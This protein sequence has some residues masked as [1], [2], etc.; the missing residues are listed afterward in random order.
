MVPIVIILLLSTALMMPVRTDG[1]TSQSSSPPSQPAPPCALQHGEPTAVVLGGDDA[2][3]GAAWAMASLGIKTLLVLTHRRDLGGDP[4]SF[5]HD[6]GHMVRTGGGLNDML[7]CSTTSTCSS[8]S[9]QE[10]HGGNTN[11]AGGPGAAFLFFDTLLRTSPLNASLEIIE[12]YIALPHSGTVDAAGR[13]SS[14]TLLHH[15]GSTCSVRTKY[16][17]DGSPEGYGA[18][19]FSLPVVFGREALHNES[20]DDPTTRAEPYAGRRSFS[21]NGHGAPI[22]A[23]SDRSV[24]TVDISSGEMTAAFPVRFPEVFSLPF[25]DSHCVCSEPVLVR[26]INS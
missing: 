26:S 14:V 5:Y 4:S 10:Q 2:G 18:A 17:V 23:W 19:A 16:A 20:T 9:S 15:D 24:E 13:V 22:E 25:Q 1:R 3:T 8:A 21:V 6:G 12:G 11:V 7:L